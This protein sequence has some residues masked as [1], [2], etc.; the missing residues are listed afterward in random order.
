[1]ISD[2]QFV[3]PPPLLRMLRSSLAGLAPETL[4]DRRLLSAA[5]SAGV[6]GGAPGPGAGDPSGASS[7]E[8]A[9]PREEPCAAERGCAGEAARKAGG[10]GDGESEK[11][12][13]ALRSRASAMGDRPARCGGAPARGGGLGTPPRG[14]RGG[15]MWGSGRTAVARLAAE[16]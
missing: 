2:V 15:S 4:A 9:E 11:E 12:S 6:L 8:V 7:V 5:S 14:A 13:C 16:P 1:M 3:A 10:A